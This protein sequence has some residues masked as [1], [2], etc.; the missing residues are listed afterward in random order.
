MST[1]PTLFDCVTRP[2]SACGACCSSQAGGRGLI[3]R[4]ARLAGHSAGLCCGPAC[5]VTCSTLAVCQC[6]ICSGYIGCR[7]AA[8]C[9]I[10]AHVQ[11]HPVS[12]CMDQMQTSLAYLLWCLW[13]PFDVC[14]LCCSGSAA[15]YMELV[16][17][18][19]VAPASVPCTWICCQRHEKGPTGYTSLSNK[20]VNIQDE[21]TP[22][23]STN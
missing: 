21:G 13:S 23:G 11:V 15:T 5:C 18:G 7:D 22:A 8:G 6:L 4:G 12:D 20:D 17:D 3:E 19:G 14:M 9:N 2:W 1:L 16:D 10:C